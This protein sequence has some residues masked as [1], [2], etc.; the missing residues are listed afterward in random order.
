MMVAVAASSGGCR[1]RE[2]CRPNGFMMKT[3]A[4]AAEDREEEWTETTCEWIVYGSVQFWT[5]GD[6]QSFFISLQ[7]GL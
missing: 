6:R 4:A 2:I 3:V 5:S 7:M 1:R